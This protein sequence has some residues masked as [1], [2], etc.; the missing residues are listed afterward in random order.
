M[1]II[2]YNNM[3]SL[4]NNYMISMGRIVPGRNAHLLVLFLRDKTA[5]FV[6][7]LVDIAFILCRLL[8]TRSTA[9]VHDVIPGIYAIYTPCRLFDVSVNYGIL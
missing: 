2:I 7:L 9:H 1:C 5:S 6:C 8:V 4:L 3:N